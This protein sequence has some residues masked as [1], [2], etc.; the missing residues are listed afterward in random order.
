MGVW[1]LHNCCVICLFCHA[2]HSRISRALQAIKRATAAQPRDPTHKNWNLERN[3]KIKL[4]P[5]NL[6]RLGACELGKWLHVMNSRNVICMGI[7][8][9]QRKKERDTP[10]PTPTYQPCHA[11]DDGA[12][13]SKVFRPWPTQ[14]GTRDRDRI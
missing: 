9:H 3:K 8:C 5:L 7:V 11:K 4:G 13:T 14:L 10:P 1:I 2:H 6:P 12:G